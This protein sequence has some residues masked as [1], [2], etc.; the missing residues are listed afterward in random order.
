MTKTTF[1]H[2][3]FYSSTGALPLWLRLFERRSYSSKLVKRSSAEWL[4]WNIYLE[5]TYYMRIILYIKY[6]KTR[7]SRINTI[8]LIQ[9]KGLRYIPHASVFCKIAHGRHCYRVW[10]EA[11]PHQQIGWEQLLRTRR[12]YAGPTCLHCTSAYKSNGK[13]R[14]IKLLYKNSR[15]MQT[16]LQWA[17]LGSLRIS[18]FWVPL[19]A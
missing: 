17:P 18:A 1:I 9:S 3:V 5:K 11:D 2:Y 15:F 13:V 16:S 6:T 8:R 19:Y 10:R 7:L 14:P 4:Q 12:S